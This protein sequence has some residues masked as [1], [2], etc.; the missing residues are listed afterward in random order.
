MKLGPLACLLL[1]AACASVKPAPVAP[2]PLERIAALEDARADSRGELV[3]L[4]RSPDAGVRERA[5]TALG[6]MP[7]PELG[8]ET[9]RALLELLRDAD[10]GVRASAA[11]GLGVR[12][13]ASAADTL[14]F[15]ALDEHERDSEPLV[16]AR[17]IE[18]A[19]KLAR[20][21][22]RERTL[23]GLR[24]ADARVRLE[25]AA[26]LGRWST[27]EAGAATHDER[28]AAH[29]ASESA[30]EVVTAGLFSLERRKTNAAGNLFV[31]YSTSSVP[32]QR[33]AS[34]RGLRA[35]VGARDVALFL[36]RA[37]QDADARVVCEALLGLGQLADRVSVPYL[38]VA[39]RH[40]SASVRRT[41]WEAIGTALGKRAEVR[42]ELKRIAV[43]VRA[44]LGS[45]RIDETS[46]WVRGAMFETALRSLATADE[47]TTLTAL[48]R[49][50]TSYRT[51]SREERSGIVRGCTELP[52]QRGL[53]LVLECIK[54][55]DF[56]VG[57][58]AIEMLPKFPAADVRPALHAALAFGDNGL[59]LAAVTA[60]LE[61][62]DRSDLEPL[63]RCYRSSQGDGTNEI[64][65]NALRAA[66]K[67]AGKDASALLVAGCGDRCAF[68]RRVAREELARVAPE[69]LPEIPPYV[70]APAEALVP[71]AGS[72]E[73]PWVDIVTSK[74]TLRFE[75]LPGEAPLHV[76]NFLTQAASERYDGTLWHR[77]VPDFVI[78]GGDYR[79]DGNGGGTWRG[80]ADSLR[81][82][83]GPRKYARGSLGMP[84]NED[85]DSGGSQLFVTHR[86]TPHLDGRYTIF[87]E[88]R[89]GFEVLD[90]IE[91]G[92]RIVDVLRVK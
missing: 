45:A 29:L 83:F 69:T 10:P 44:P 20:P 11:F 17:C 51:L 71:L 80:A 89:A 22:L 61:M 30:P 35:L 15:V 38:A 18:A 13:D 91:V 21:E 41:A 16:R 68:V 34:I 52:A 50:G 2:S 70:E 65:F 25:A 54:D 26:A 56:A 49:I 33:I 67:G 74:G 31:Q 36:Q 81:H 79:G 58:V 48:E 28:L 90:A 32:E 72:D 77:V 46:P 3:V 82:E 8:V 40:G 59:R 47:A 27:K 12:G 1:G 62:P 64:R 60:L 4:A 63:E 92:D 57:G 24:D 55:T 42:E 76:H 39:V 6:R 14:L 75:L 86:A 88:L 43:D 9:T 19:G 66:A 53:P 7:Y 78:Q 23:E 85:P 37:S 5:A 84:R 73:N 87:G